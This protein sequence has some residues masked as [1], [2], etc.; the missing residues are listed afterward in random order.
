MIREAEARREVEICGLLSAKHG[1]PCR[2]YPVRNIAGDARH[3]FA[4]D[5]AEQIAAMRTMRDRQ[6]SL[7]AIYHSHPLGPAQPSALD[8]AE[9]AYP[10]VL[11]LIIALSTAGETQLGGFYL[12][13]HSPE[14]VELDIQPAGHG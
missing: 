12:H 2:L 3:R 10:D 1:Q 14:R 9:A 6:E 7:F 8:M 4:M 13:D 11:Y 5:P